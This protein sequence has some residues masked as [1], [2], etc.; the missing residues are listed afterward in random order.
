MFEKY[1][2]PGLQKQVEIQERTRQRMA[3]D[4]TFTPELGDGT[5]GPAIA[6]YN[7]ELEKRFKATVA[8]VIKKR[9]DSK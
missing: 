5:Q 1:I 3:D 7:E 6:Y 8:E 9:T 4:P 2:K